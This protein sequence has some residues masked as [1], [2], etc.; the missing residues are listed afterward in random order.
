[1]PAKSKAQFRFLEALI[2]GGLKSPPEGF[3]K[4]QAQEFIDKTSSYRDLP[5]KAVP[6]K[7]PKLKKAWTK[8]S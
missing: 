7:Y 2:H 8:K 4:P 6:G 1:M 5:E 3:S